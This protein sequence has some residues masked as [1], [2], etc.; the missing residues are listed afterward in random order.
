MWTLLSFSPSLSLAFSLL[1]CEC[2]C[3]FWG[4][5]KRSDGQPRSSSPSPQSHHLPTLPNLLACMK[6]C[7]ALFGSVWCSVL[8]HAVP[9]HIVLCCAVLCRSVPCYAVSQLNGKSSVKSYGAE[10]LTPALS[11]LG[12]VRNSTAA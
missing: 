6:E 8:C 2:V 3:V 7:V 10:I 4:Q 12:E 5:G 1:L 11:L 9:C